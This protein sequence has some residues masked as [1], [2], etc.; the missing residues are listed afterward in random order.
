[1]R[2]KKQ[3]KN[4]KKLLLTSLL[5][6]CCVS[7]YSQEAV[8]F[9][10]IGKTLKFN[11]EKFYLKWSSHPRDYYYIQEWVPKKE[12]P[13]TYNQMFTVTLHLSEELTPALAVQ[14][15]VAE[16]EKRSETDKC[17]NYNVFENDGEYILDFL[18]SEGEEGYLKVVEHDIHHYKQVHINGK[19]ALQLNFYS[20]RSYGDDILPFLQKLQEDRT[21]LIEAVTKMKIKCYQKN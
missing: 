20:H 2:V 1:M 21:V 17:C 4:M 6:F 7:L 8:D 18:V 5:F 10:Q 11:G 14:Y 13:E 3:T 9:L 12:S 15:K 19:K 16:L